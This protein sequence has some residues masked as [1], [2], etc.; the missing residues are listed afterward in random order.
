MTF[1]FQCPYVW[2]TH[3]CKKSNAGDIVDYIFSKDASMAKYDIL[4]VE[5]KLKKIP[6]SIKYLISDSF[7]HSK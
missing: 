1:F 2:R 5:D 3:Q 7:Y 4:L 6:E